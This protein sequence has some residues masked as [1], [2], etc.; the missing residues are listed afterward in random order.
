MESNEKFCMTNYSFVTSD[1]DNDTSSTTFNVTMMLNKEISNVRFDIVFKLPDTDTDTKFNRQL[2]RTS[3]NMTR[4][5]RGVTGNSL[6]KYLMDMMLKNL[7]FELI[8]PMKPGV[9]RMINFQY[10]GE[11][12]PPI[13][14]KVY[15]ECKMFGKFRILQNV[16]NFGRCTTFEVYAQLS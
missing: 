11:F 5:L 6:I 7:D 9:Y 14:T 12:L 16:K 2:F 15:F 8:F 13:T 4:V 3:I 10:K 1:I